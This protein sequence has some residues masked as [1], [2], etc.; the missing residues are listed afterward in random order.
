MVV[1]LCACGKAR[2]EPVG[3]PDPKVALA[4]LPVDRPFEVA[5]DTD[6]GTVRCELDPRAAPRAVSLF[7]GF[8]TGR[9]AWRDPKSARVL[10][11][12]LY[13]NTPFF[14]LIPG[15]LVQSGSPS[16]DSTGTPGY[17]IAVEAHDDD[18]I[19][20]RSPG[21]LALARYTPPPGRVDP[22]P[23]PPGMVLGSQFFITLTDM[24]HLAG[25]V[26]VLGR[27]E[28]LDVVRQIARSPN[29][30]APMPMLNRVRVPGAD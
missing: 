9:A 8:S 30:G 25:S 16:G 18:V 21:A 28:P 19:R 10:R 3:P 1:C 24:S 22:H 26:S 20:L 29:R 23:P 6:R 4:G 11:E 12:P 7:V 5:L 27:C 17:R 15:V 2:I 14:R 13:R